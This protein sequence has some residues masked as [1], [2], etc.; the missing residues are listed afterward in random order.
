MES[1]ELLNR[2]VSTIPIYDINGV[3]GIPILTNFDDIYECV[4]VI[5]KGGTSTVYCYKEK[6]T[7]YLFAVKE[8][9]IFRNTNISL[10]K[11]EINI[12]E[13]LN[14]LNSESIVKYYNSFIRLDGQNHLLVI[15][16]E[17]IEGITLENHIQN[18]N[19]NNLS[20]DF[21]TILKIAYWL[22]NTI[23]LLHEN[24][25]V[26]RD[27]K[28]SNI[29]ITE[30]RLVL[31]DVGLTCTTNKN[32]KTLLCNSGQFDGTIPYIAP[33]AW[34]PRKFLKNDN[35]NNLKKL[36]V[37]AA[38]ITLYYLIEGKL[39]WTEKYA[40]RLME[41]ITGIYSIPYIKSKNLQGLLQL[42][43]Q[44]NPNERPSAKKVCSMIIDYL[45]VI[46]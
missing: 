9:P 13:N 45:N 32:N 28:P 34:S 37:W 16:M 38:G 40:F 5:G 14:N 23:A 43:L 26:H 35:I 39:P 30:N 8:I 19:D 10:L 41:Q 4:K 25:Y 24:G 1:L 46:P 22:F 2:A 15:V 42:I 21:K 7:G 3:D 33:E 31:I 29:M 6:S 12:L 44:R 11:S 18:I 17:C 27:I 20:I 36:D